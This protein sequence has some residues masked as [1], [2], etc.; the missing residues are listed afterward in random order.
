MKNVGGRVGDLGVQLATTG[1]VTAGKD[2][3]CRVNA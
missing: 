3:G 1:K 2:Q